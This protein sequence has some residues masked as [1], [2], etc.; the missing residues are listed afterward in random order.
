MSTVLVV[1]GTGPTG[2]AVV[3]RLLA[4]G[5]TVTILHTGAH[6]VDFGPGGE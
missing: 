6:E 2:Y 4:E 5:T 1:G 3:R